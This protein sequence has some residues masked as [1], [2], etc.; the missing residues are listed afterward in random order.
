MNYTITRCRHKYVRLEAT[1]QMATS[2]DMVLIG[3]VIELVILPPDL[4]H[5]LSLSLSLSLSLTHTHTHT[6][7]HTRT[8]THTQGTCRASLLAS[9]LLGR[10][11]YCKSSQH[12]GHTIKMSLKHSFRVVPNT[13]THKHTH[14]H[15]HMNTLTQAHPSM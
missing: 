2:G 9:P 12:E 14:T 15:T 8:H 11:V 3:L 5:T 10:T 4:T 13:H 1:K 7:T 6:H